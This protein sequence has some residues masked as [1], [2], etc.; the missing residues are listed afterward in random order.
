G[1]LA[2]FL[3]NAAKYAPEPSPI[4]VRLSRNGP[5]VRIAVAD[6]GPGIEPDDQ[7]RLF[8]RYFRA[9][10]TADSTRGLGLGLYLCRVIAEHHGG[11]VGVDSVPGRG[12]TF[13]IDL[14][15]AQ[16]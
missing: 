10:R 15:L 16:T 6:H 1:V 9:A 5:H 8:Q 4:E 13:W 7:R 3:D 14:A 11:V 2:N 12:A